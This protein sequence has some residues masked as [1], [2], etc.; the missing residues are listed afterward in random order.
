[1]KPFFL[2]PSFLAA[3]LTRFFVSF[4]ILSEPFNAIETV[5]FETPAYSA[6]SFIVVRFCALFMLIFQLFADITVI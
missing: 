5:N 1:M 3:S 4:L 2:Y 6:M